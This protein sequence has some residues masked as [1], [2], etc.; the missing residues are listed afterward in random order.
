MPRSSPFIRISTAI[1]VVGSLAA[2]STGCSSSTDGPPKTATVQPHSVSAG[3]PATSTPSTE[4]PASPPSTA[5]PKDV[6]S[7]ARTF[8]TAYAEHD[9]R[10][11]KD[12]SYADAGARAAKL[13]AGELVSILGQQRPSQDASWAALRAEKARQSVRITSVVVPDGAPAVTQSSA[14]IRVGYN[15]T[16]TPQ[17]GEERHSNEQLALRL[18][19]TSQGWRV[20]AM[21]WA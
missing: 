12:G 8:T 14:L 13:A 18:E 10:D 15:L 20:T 6:E 21:P 4:G 9:A 3:I 1:S 2:L 19:H 5:L 11:G 16:T 17:S 7:T